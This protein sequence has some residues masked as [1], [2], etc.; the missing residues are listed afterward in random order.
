MKDVAREAGVS[1]GTV[2]NVFNGAAV[3]REY[4]QRV[5]EAALR[6]GYTVNSYARGLRT[7]KTNTFAVIF[8]DLENIF[9]TRFANAIC[10][11]L[12][13]QHCRMMLV[14]TEYDPQA[15]VECIRMLRQSMVDGI[16]G[17]TY[18]A[19]RLDVEGMPY[20]SIDRVISPSVPCVTSDN[21]G[22][23]ALAARTL[24]SLGCSR[25]L[26]LRLGSPIIGETDKRGSG[27]AAEC[28]IRN[29]DCTLKRFNDEEGM[30]RVLSFLD[31]NIRDGR[32]AWDGVFCSTD[33]L[34][35]HVVRHLARRGVRVPQDVQIIGY[36]GT[37][38]FFSGEYTCST[39]V[40]PVQQM[41]ET[42]VD[43]LTHWNQARP[44]LIA[45]PVRYQPGGTTKDQVIPD[46]Q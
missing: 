32:L 1:L 21:Y 4:R 18:S 20:V 25:L 23:G 34:V 22:G 30:D 9:F 41:A 35:H 42:C 45:L 6:L 10:R 15:E 19:N 3:G 27:F 2:S 24:L 44:A 29:A 43:I 38:A 13:R 28:V 8:P 33:L 40:Q 37:R 11:E 5:E 39:I 36:D 12:T 31:E 14:T 7:E 16:I 26:F 17:L 46:G